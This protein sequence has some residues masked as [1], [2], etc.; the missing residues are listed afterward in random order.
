MKA[1]SVGTNQAELELDNNIRILFSY[2]IPVAAIMG[3]KLFRT[4][5]SHSR[6]TNRHI[7]HWLRSNNYE[8]HKVEVKSQEWFNDLMP[9]TDGPEPRS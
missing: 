6:I 3:D 4:A 1:R 8:A 2:E 5:L 7:G 9:N